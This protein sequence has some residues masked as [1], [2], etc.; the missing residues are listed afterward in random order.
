MLFLLAHLEKRIL[1][2]LNEWYRKQKKGGRNLR[3]LRYSLAFL[4]LILIGA[5]I[6]GCA[7]D[8]TVKKTSQASTSQLTASKLISNIK[9]N[10]KNHSVTD[11][12][13][14]GLKNVDGQGLAFASFNLDGQLKYAN[15]YDSHQKNENGFGIGLFT[16]TKAVGSPIQCV[17]QVGGDGVVLITGIVVDDPEIKN[18][19]I[20]FS[21]GSINQVPVINGRFWFGGKVGSSF[22]DSNSNKVL[23]VTSN[24]DIVMNTK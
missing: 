4:T 5:G 3:E 10:E 18:I 6:S 24:G 1:F 2:T 15:I 7:T 11:I 14:I 20:T 12:S 16:A 8:T 17:E 19:I 21:N 23:G 9:Q 13:I 22:H